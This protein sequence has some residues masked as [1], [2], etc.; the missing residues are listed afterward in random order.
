M[1]GA[2]AACACAFDLGGDCHVTLVATAERY[3]GRGL[4]GAVM[5]TAVGEAAARGQATTSLV[6]TQAGYPLY[7]RMGYE[8]VG[9]VQM[10]ERR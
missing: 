10:W 2:P 5:W 9:A 6:A 3:R 8:D 4:A 1:D 7:R